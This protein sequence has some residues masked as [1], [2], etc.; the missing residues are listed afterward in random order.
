MFPHLRANLFLV[1]AT[2]LISAVVYPFALWGVG[3]TILP[4]KANGSL[5]RDEAGQPIGS[6]LIAQPFT[7]DE[8]FQPRPSAV[9]YN[10]AAS[11]A[12]NWSAS[13]YLLR[14]RVARILGPIVKYR[15]GARTG[16]LVAPD[17]E[18]WFRNDRYQGQK[19]IVAQWALAHP[20]LAQNWVKADQQN[21][22]YVAA[23]RA[24]HPVDVAQ[25]LREKPDLPEPTSADLAVLFFTHFSHTSPGTFPALVTARDMAGKEVKQIRP[26]QS[27]SEIQSTFFDM[28]RQE[29][30]EVDLEPVPADM[31]MASGS[32]LDPHITLQNALY[33]L[34]RVASKW[35][36]LTNRGCTEIHHEIK[37]L[38]HQHAEA[39]LAGLAGVDLVNVLEINLA[40]KN[41]YHPA[42]SR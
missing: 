16:Q 19:G 25:W 7:G 24:Q 41:R 31:V 39:P 15:G 23:W 8:Y 22:Q 6:R 40:L 13:N 3:Q 36:T 32:G 27:G 34:D 1:A 26:V 20:T 10:A 21:E 30:P 17:L 35:S 33:Q 9:S 28:W 14:D 11:G 29:H 37:E 2:L 18:A 42:Q 12:S 4:T 5:V 38:L